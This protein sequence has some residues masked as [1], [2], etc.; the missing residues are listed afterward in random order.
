MIVIDLFLTRPGQ[1]HSYLNDQGGKTMWPTSS[2][3]KRQLASTQKPETVSRS[4]VNKA[5]QAV[6]DYWENRNWTNARIK[7]A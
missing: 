1:V 4:I 2:K 7:E 3:I 5:L 6:S